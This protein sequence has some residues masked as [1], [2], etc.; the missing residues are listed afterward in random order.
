MIL[1][2]T[3]PTPIIYS[4]IGSNVS[5]N[6]TGP[7]GAG[8]LIGFIDITFFFQVFL[9]VADS[10]S[11]EEEGKIYAVFFNFSLVLVNSACKSLFTKYAL[12]F[13]GASQ[14]CMRRFAKSIF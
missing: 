10:G 11:I 14:S 5:D 2:N 13:Q 4:A 12:M 9:K 6:T 8:K 1:V 7:F 3:V